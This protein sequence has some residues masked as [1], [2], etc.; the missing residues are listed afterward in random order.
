MW[1][2]E[3]YHIAFDIDDKDPSGGKR[4]EQIRLDC[5]NRHG[6]HSD[7][8]TLEFVNQNRSNVRTIADLTK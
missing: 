5:Q 4:N 8:K 6:T 2:I 1:V 3:D 7:S